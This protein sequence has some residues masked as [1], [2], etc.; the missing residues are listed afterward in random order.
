MSLDDLLL[1]FVESRPVPIYGVADVRGF[2]NALPGWHPKEL[3]PRCRRVI[4]LGHPFFEH[5]LRVEKRTHIANESWW[6]ANRI[7]YRIP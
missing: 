7:V 4:V 1:E 3:M 2:S 6:G 5:P